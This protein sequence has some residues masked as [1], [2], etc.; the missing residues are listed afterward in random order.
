MT[1]FLPFTYLVE[2]EVDLKFPGEPDMEEKDIIPLPKS[3]YS[4]ERFF[5]LVSQSKWQSTQEIH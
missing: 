2:V 5:Y 3:N 4:W 1:T